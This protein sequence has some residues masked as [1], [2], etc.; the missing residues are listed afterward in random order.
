MLPVRN[1]NLSKLIKA[2][3]PGFVFS[4]EGSLQEESDLPRM[5]TSDGFNPNAFKLMKLSG[6]DFSQPMSLGHVIE[7][8]PYG[9]N[10]TQRVIQS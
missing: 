4:S 2:S 7:V 9:L 3:L 5:H 1:V 10:S 8:K 6:Y